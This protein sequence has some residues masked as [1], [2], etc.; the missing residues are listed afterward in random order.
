MLLLADRWAW[1]GRSALWLLLPRGRSAAGG[2]GCSAGVL[3]LVSW[4]AVRRPTC[5]LLGNWACRRVFCML[6][7]VTLGSAVATVTFRKPGLLAHLVRHV[8]AGHGRLVPRFKGAQFL[9][10]ATIV[11]YA[12]AILVTFLFVLMLAQPEGH[13]FYDRLSWEPASRRARRP[14]P[15][16]VGMLAA[17]AWSDVFQDRRRSPSAMSVA[18][19]AADAAR[20]RSCVRQ[21]MAHLGRRAVQQ[22]LIAVEVPARCCWSALVGAD[23][24]RDSRQASTASSAASTRRASPWMRSAMNEV[25]CCTTT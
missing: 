11:V 2:R 12:G 19:R 17:G 25:A 9:G 1:L 22:Q 13:A 5:R 24:H 10:V 6:A 21:H 15:C 3:A 4:R 23:R 8:A 14:A 7:A 18:N 20:R 16:C